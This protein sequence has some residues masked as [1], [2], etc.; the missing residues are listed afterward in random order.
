[1]DLFEMDLGEYGAPD[2]SLRDR[3]D[4]TGHPSGSVDP[5]I[6]TDLINPQD[7]VLRREDGADYRDLCNNQL[8]GFHGMQ[9]GH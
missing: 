4:M 9:D 3:L 5:H 8:P 6:N 1:M 7:R 2:F